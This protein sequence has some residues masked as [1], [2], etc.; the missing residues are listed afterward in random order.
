MTFINGYAMPQSWW[1][2]HLSIHGYKWR[3]S[4]KG[5]KLYWPGIKLERTPYSGS[6]SIFIVFWPGCYIVI[7]W[8]NNIGCCPG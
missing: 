1:P 7:S 2:R 5:T 6:D 4:S 3:G 8:D